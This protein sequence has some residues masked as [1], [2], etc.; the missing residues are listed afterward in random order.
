MNANEAT[1]CILMNGERERERD[2]L[3]IVDVFK[4]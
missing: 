2:T 1:S 4:Q 3:F